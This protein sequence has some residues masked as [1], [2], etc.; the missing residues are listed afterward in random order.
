MTIQNASKIIN[1]QKKNAKEKKLHQKIS[2][3]PV[4]VELICLSSGTNNFDTPEG[5]VFFPQARKNYVEAP[6]PGQLAISFETKYQKEIADCRDLLSRVL[7]QQEGFEPKKLEELLGKL[8]KHKEKMVVGICFF[9]WKLRCSLT[10][11][12][13]VRL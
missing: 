4:A 11:L 9:L 3:V 12:R 2:T 1:E 8:K 13:E 10:H 5:T 7:A 6:T